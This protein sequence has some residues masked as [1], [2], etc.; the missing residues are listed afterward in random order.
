MVKNYK[1]LLDKLK[2]EIL[3]QP[4]NIILRFAHFHKSCNYCHNIPNF[5]FAT[6]QS[7]LFYTV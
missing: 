1:F 7:F 3:I 4:E 6:Q 2:K 5:A